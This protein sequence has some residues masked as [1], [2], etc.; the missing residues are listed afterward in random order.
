MTTIQNVKG[1]ENLSSFQV[2]NITGYHRSSCV[3]LHC[4]EFHFPEPAETSTKV[5]GSFT[6][7]LTYI[8]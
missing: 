2:A 4:L 6:V 7:I 8:K 3:D 1:K 5:S